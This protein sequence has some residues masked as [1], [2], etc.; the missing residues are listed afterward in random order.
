MNLARS[1]R[2]AAHERNAPSQEGAVQFPVADFP[3]LA[4]GDD[5]ANV[6]VCGSR[7]WHPRARGATPTRTATLSA[8]RASART[9]GCAAEGL[10]GTGRPVAFCC[11]ERNLL[12]Q[13]HRRCRASLCGLISGGGRNWERR[14]RSFQLVVMYSQHDN[15]YLQHMYNVCMCACTAALPPAAQDLRL[16]MYSS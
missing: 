1:S 2:S 15:V 12:A 8:A 6:S 14:K 9:W 13:P 3:S 7:H 16:R 5:A 11:A 4:P 10:Y